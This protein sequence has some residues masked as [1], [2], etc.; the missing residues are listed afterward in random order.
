MEFYIEQLENFTLGLPAKLNKLLKQLNENAS[1]LSDIDVK[2]MLSSPVTH[3]F[4]ARK[5]DNK[6]IVGMLT[7]V[8]FR[9]PF[10]KKGLI[11]DVVVDEQYRGKGIGTKLISTAI[12]QARQEK[13]KYLDLTSHPK[14]VAADRLYQHLGFKKRDTNIYRIKLQ[15]AI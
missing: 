1:P 12:N 14:R 11:E 2:N 6:E 9:I 8:V 7:L 3:L 5:S 13:V 4:I 15:N 10:A